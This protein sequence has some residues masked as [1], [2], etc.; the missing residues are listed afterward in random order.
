[1]FNYIQIQVEW[2]VDIQSEFNAKV[3][4]EKYKRNETHTQK[5]KIYF[6]ATKKRAFQCIYAHPRFKIMSNGILPSCF[7]YRDFNETIYKNK[8]TSLPECSE[9]N[10]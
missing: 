3:S 1:M 6:N 9:R 8:R 10:F 4:S 2:N 5:K 7:I